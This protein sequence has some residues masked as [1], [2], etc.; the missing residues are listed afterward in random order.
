MRRPSSSWKFLSIPSWWRS[1]R[2][3]QHASHRRLRLE[4][5]SGRLML[6]A[7]VATF[8]SEN[9]P[10]ALESTADVQVGGVSSLEPESG[11]LVVDGESPSAPTGDMSPLAPTVQPVFTIPT[12]SIASGPC[13]PE[14]EPPGT[15]VTL[16]RL[17]PPDLYPLDLPP[18]ELNPPPIFVIPFIPINPPVVPPID[19]LPPPNPPLVVPPIE[20]PFP[21]IPGPSGPM[22]APPAPSAPTAPSGPISPSAPSG[23]T[24][25]STAPTSS[26]SGA[27]SPS[28]PSGPTWALEPGSPSSPTGP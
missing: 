15:D 5:L 18:I 21:M 1:K 23:P 13:D 24:D 26:P 11:G 3:A 27:M 4:Q 17:P 14:S 20:I 9:D 2:R 6:A 12:G 19:P 10:P 25:P 22:P 7:D 8:D 16:C 28:L